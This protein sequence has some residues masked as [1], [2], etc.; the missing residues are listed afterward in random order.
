MHSLF[1]KNDTLSRVYRSDERT[2]DKN[3]DFAKY[4]GEGSLLIIRTPLSR[5]FLLVS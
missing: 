1:S 4:E 3:L 2:D 5:I